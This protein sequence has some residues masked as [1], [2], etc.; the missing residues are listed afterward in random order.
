MVDYGIMEKEPRSLP[1]LRRRKAALENKIAS[2]TDVLEH[3]EDPDW[4][5]QKN[6]RAEGLRLDIDPKTKFSRLLNTVAPM[7]GRLG[8]VVLP[9]YQLELGDIDQEIAQKFREAPYG[10]SF[11]N[12]DGEIQDFSSIR[13][14]PQVRE[15]IGLMPDRAQSLINSFLSSRQADVIM[16]HV[17]AFV[18]ENESQ[19][20]DFRLAGRAF[21]ELGYIHLRQKYTGA[22]VVVLSPDD[23]F[24]IGL[25]LHPDNEVIDNYGLQKSFKG[26]TL[27]DGIIVRETGEHLVVDAIIE[28]KNI[29]T[30]HDD[31]VMRQRSQYSAWQFGRDLLLPDR[32]G[33]DMES[34]LGALIGHLRPE[35]QPKPVVVNPDL[36][37][38]Y[39]VPEN[40][41]LTLTDTFFESVP[42]NTIEF[43]RLLA[44]LRDEVRAYRPDADTTTPDLGGVIPLSTH[45]NVETPTDSEKGRLLSEEEVRVSGILVQGLLTNTRYWWER[46]QGE[47]KDQSRVSMV[48]DRSIYRIYPPLELR[49]I[50]NNV[51]RKLKKAA[52]SADPQELLSEEEKEIW[53]KVGRLEQILDREVWKVTGFVPRVYRK[54]KTAAQE[55]YDFH[56]EMKGADWPV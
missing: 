30:I 52:T 17:A 38:I 50:L 40:A 26:K 25:N 36:K 8:R 44:V 5:N 9:R 14:R 10:F 27:P 24:D 18:P 1:E 12:L 28:Y 49:T 22:G 32:N 56:P 34:Y 23:I 29:R 4:R 16:T 3:I 7:R 51:Y 54:I 53:E 55:Y 43:S 6:T 35:L 39:A 21:E 47:L 37:V 46:L 15:V 33:F 31:S 2:A 41:D 42:V 48:R 20:K 19:D 11:V 13:T 45:Q